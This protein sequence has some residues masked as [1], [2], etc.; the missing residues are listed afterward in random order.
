M[1]GGRTYLSHSQGTLCLHLLQE[2]THT[3]SDTC[4]AAEPTCRTLKGHCACICCKKKHTLKVTHVRRQNLPVALSRDTVLAPVARKNET[5]RVEQDANNSPRTGRKA[6]EATVERR[7]CI[8]VMTMVT[9]TKRMTICAR[10][11]R[12]YAACKT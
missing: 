5:K 8:P 7:K 4:P 2:K 6:I 11:N 3:K 10:Y 9:A 12:N 1:S